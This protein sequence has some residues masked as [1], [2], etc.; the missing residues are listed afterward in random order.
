[1]AGKSVVND[2]GMLWL[3]VPS[4]P[5][6]YFLLLPPI[7]AS[8]VKELVNWKFSVLLNLTDNLKFLVLAALLLR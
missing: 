6:F 2:V 1:M 3:V 4:F 7:P 5:S 8:Q